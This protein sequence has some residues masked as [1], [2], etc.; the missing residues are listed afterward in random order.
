MIHT[1]SGRGRS[2]I[3][4]IGGKD[5]PMNGFDDPSMAFDQRAPDNFRHAAQIDDNGLA[6]L[7]HLVLFLCSY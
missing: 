7:D 5:A 2:L 4:V 1:I 3:Q 6:V